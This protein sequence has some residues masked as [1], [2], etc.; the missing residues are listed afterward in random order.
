MPLQHFSDHVLKMMNR[1]NDYKQAIALTEK[2]RKNYPKITLR[3]TLMVGF[4]GETQKDYE[5]LK[6]SVAQVK[7]DRL[8]VFAFSKEEDTAAFLL[9]ETVSEEEK[10]DR[11]QE[12]MELQQE[13]SYQKNQE[14]VSQ[15]FKVLIDEYDESIF[16]YIGRS[17]EYAPDSDGSIYIASENQLKIGEFYDVK[18]VKAEFHDLM[19]EVV[20]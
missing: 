20:S 8:G 7:F 19:G 4:P 10:L 6:A 11:K 1:Q 16:M 17:Y 14:K 18:I 2:I 5:L 15:T 13:I 12:I 3:T 9:D